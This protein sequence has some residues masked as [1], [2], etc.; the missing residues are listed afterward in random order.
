MKEI[1]SANTILIQVDGD[2]TENLADTKNVM[3][4]FLLYRSS[5]RSNL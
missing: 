2:G 1:S 5:Y 3:N 4:V